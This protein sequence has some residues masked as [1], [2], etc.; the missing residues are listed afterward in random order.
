MSAITTGQS[1]R[2]GVTGTPHG[3][4]V[5]VSGDEFDRA[6]DDTLAELGLDRDEFIRR[7][8][9]GDLDDDRARMLW[10]MVGHDLT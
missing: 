8:R 3:L 1:A 5:A 2:P 10:S 9:A 7:G 6:L 4:V